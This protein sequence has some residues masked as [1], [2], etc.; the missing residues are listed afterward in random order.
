MDILGQLVTE[1][2][3]HNEEER[4]IAQKNREQRDGHKLSMWAR[5]GGE[6]DA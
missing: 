6:Q 2:P 4:N 1:A 5:Q 3:R